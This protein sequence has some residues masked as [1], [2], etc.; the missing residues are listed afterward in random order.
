MLI[1][2]SLLKYCNKIFDN[3]SYFIDIYDAGSLENFLKQTFKEFLVGLMEVI[4]EYYAAFISKND[5]ITHMQEMCHN[6]SRLYSRELSLSGK[7]CATLAGRANKFLSDFVNTADEYTTS[8][9]FSKIL[10]QEIECIDLEKWMGQKNIELML[11]SPLVQLK[12][13]DDAILLISDLLTVRGSIPELVFHEI[14]GQIFRQYEIALKNEVSA[15]SFSFFSLTKPKHSVPD[16]VATFLRS[17]FSSQNEQ[18]SSPT[19]VRYSH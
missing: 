6:L 18:S 2:I 14:I 15:S 1:P 16:N 7:I 3:I 10:G 8:A 11:S 12:N 5:I 13:L 9:D 4:K 17:E 19:T